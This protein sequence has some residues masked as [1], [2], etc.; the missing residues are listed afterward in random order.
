MTGTNKDEQIGCNILGIAGK[1]Q[2]GK[3]TA[4]NYLVG[5][6]LVAME[7]VKGGMFINPKGEL[8]VTDI[9]GNRDGHDVILDLTRRD[10]VMLDFLDEY[11]NPYIKVYSFADPLK[12]LCMDIMG[13]TH[14][15]CYGTNEEKD[16]PTKYAWQRMPGLT[17]DKT[18]QM[19]AREVMQYVG[20]DIFRKMGPNIWVN[21]TIRR[22]QLEQPMLAI[23]PDIRF[24]NEV[25][26][27]QK[28]GGKVI[29]LTRNPLGDSDQH[30]SETALDNY[31]GFDAILDNKEDTINC[32]CEQLYKILRP[33]GWLPELK[34]RQK[35]TKETGK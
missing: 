15:Q 6:Y 22:I 18:G 9:L 24:P 4:S 28:A 16:S 11:V 8:Q 2:S 13:L 30:F 26:G 3:T 5:T 23:I 25:K 34:E 29:K 19:T 1:K 21:A 14:K 32:Q 17:S 31:E 7:V 35:P 20:T 12:W 33:W 10:N 27:V